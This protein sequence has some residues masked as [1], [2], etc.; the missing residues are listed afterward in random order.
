MLATPVYDTPE[1]NYVYAIQS[2]RE[3]LHK[4]GI[5]TAYVLLSGNAHVDDARNTIVHEF[6]LSDCTDLVFLDADVSWWPE[7]LVDLCQFDCDVIGGVYPF[8]REDMR[9][10]GR[11]PVKLAPNVELKDGLIEV[12]GLPTGFLRIRRHVLERLAST[13]AKFWNRQ[14]RRQQVPVIFEREMHNGQRWGGDVNFCRKWRELGGKVYAAAE[15]PL[16]HTAKV[17]IVDSLAASLRR[18]SG[19]SLRHCADRIR[20]GKEIPDTYREAQMAVDNRWGASAE[21]LAACVILARK[22]N[23]PILEMGSGLSTILMAAATTQ[24]VWCVEHNRQFA[25]HLEEMADAAGTPN[26]AIV[27]CDIADNWYDLA[28]D[29]A[30]MPGRYAV[31]LVDGPPRQY[32]RMR[33]FDV[34]GDHVNAIVCDDADDPE[35][36]EQI[37]LW[38][39]DHGRELKMEGG[40]LALIMPKAHQVAA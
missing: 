2:S 40:R 30:D 5:Q 1:P 8:R 26:I 24:T 16:G 39:A 3:A 10:T 12:E 20:T 33:F 15:I 6:L 21:V 25:E 29:L 9:D 18:V 11:M 36:A 32:D 4:I 37:R 17:K 34:F 38:A 28:D 23:G 13:S 27:T 7:H 22:A 19:S 31:A 14:D 35:L